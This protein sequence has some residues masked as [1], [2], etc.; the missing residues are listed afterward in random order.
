MQNDAIMTSRCMQLVFGD[1]R[2]VNLQDE[3][4]LPVTKK[5]SMQKGKKSISPRMKYGGAN[6]LKVLLKKHKYTTQYC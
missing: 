2:D 4:A 3:S 6:L 1:K 5:E